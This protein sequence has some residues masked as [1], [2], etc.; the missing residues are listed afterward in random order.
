MI[1]VKRCVAFFWVVLTIADGSGCGRAATPKTAPGV[2]ITI[3][4]LGLDR[5]DDLRRDALE[6]FTRN[7]GIHT[8]LIPT[9]GSSTE[10][11]IRMLRLLN[12]HA[13]KPDIFVVDVIWPGTL[14]GQLLDLRTYLDRDATRYLPELLGNDTVDGRIVS[15]PFYV[16]VGMLYFRKDLLAKYGYRRPPATWQQLEAMARRI[17]NGERAAGDHGFAGYVWQGASYEGLT[18]N[19]L[20]WQESFGGGH[21][22][23]ADRTISVNNRQVAQALRQAAGWIGAIS[24]PSVLSY[25][26]ADTLNTFRTG[27]AA[28][29]RYWSSGFPRRQWDNRVDVALLPAGPHGRAQ[30]M[31]GF[32]LAVSRYTA[33]PR[34]AA[35]TALWLSSPEVQLRRALRHGFLPTIAALYER[36]ELT[37]ALP[38]A[39]VLGPSGIDSWIARPSSVAG[40]RYA[41]VSRA[42]YE[43]VH[44]VLERKINPEPA[45]AA[46]EKQLS[47]ITGFGSRA[48]GSAH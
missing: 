12:Q 24:S 1:A 3:S 11:L 18:C 19:A 40:S 27:H 6:E 26:E 44:A 13:Q 30:S 47:E 22:I 28:F 33:H 17:Q 43:T 25:T 29:M 31:G 48:R 4:G 10:Q 23:E 21:I 36:P 9:F 15:L 34:E 8:D 7:T 16:N 37:S 5:A 2:S 42:Y 45:L 14:A 46:L 39:A 32:Q 38:Q 41:L 20:E 35:Q